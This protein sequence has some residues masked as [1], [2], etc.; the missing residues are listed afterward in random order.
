MIGL[1]GDQQPS[2]CIIRH[3]HQV[4]KLIFQSLKVILMIVD[5]VL[6]TVASK[7]VLGQYAGLERPHLLVD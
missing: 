7:H 2:Y 1:V 3:G 4:T 6:E 5:K